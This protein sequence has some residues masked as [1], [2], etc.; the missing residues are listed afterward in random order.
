MIAAMTVEIASLLA[1]M[2]FKISLLHVPS[3]AMNLI[4]S[5][6]RAKVA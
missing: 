6:K 5:Q 1:K 3:V 2:G 4:K